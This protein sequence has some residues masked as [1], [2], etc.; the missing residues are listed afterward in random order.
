MT[1]PDH[2]VTRLTV[3]PTR[4]RTRARMLVL[5]VCLAVLPIAVGSVPSGLSPASA[6]PASHLAPPVGTGSAPAY[7]AVAHRRSAAKPVAT[8]PAWVLTWADEFNGTTAGA[9]PDPTKWVA[10]VGGHGW[11]NQQLEYDTAGAAN[12][13]LSGHGVL[14]MR[15][16][17]GANPYTCWYGPCTYTSSRITTKGRFAQAYGRFEARM[18]IPCGAGLWPAFWALGNDIDTVGWPASGEIDVM[19]NIGREPSTVHGTVHG[20]G[21]SAGSAITGSLT[22]ASRLCDAYHVYSSTWTPTTISFAV[23]GTT[24]RTITTADTAGRTWVFQHPYFLLLDLAVG[25]TWPGSPNASTV[26]SAVMTVDY[27]RVYRAA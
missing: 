26:F 15:A 13:F 24:Y 23:D 9:A 3:P 18:R 20:P 17:K 5:L 21:Y 25:G 7:G 2:R 4:P 10:D 27:V 12:A 22:L 16:Q 11:G 8:A 1:N 14:V 19:E 6:A